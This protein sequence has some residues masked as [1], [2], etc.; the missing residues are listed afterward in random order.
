MYDRPTRLPILGLSQP[1]SDTYSD[2]QE[3]L[4]SHMNNYMKALSC[5]THQQPMNIH[6]DRLNSPYLP[7][8]ACIISTPQHQS[9]QV[10]GSYTQTGPSNN[11]IT[12]SNLSIVTS[13]GPNLQTPVHS[14]APVPPVPSNNN[15]TAQTAPATNNNMTAH[16][17]SA[18]NM[19]SHSIPMNSLGTH[20]ISTNALPAYT[21]S[22]NNVTNHNVSTSNQIITTQASSHVIAPQVSVAQSTAVQAQTH[23]TTQTTADSHSGHMVMI[24]T[25]GKTYADSFYVICPQ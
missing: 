17:I 20:T 10:L 3:A 12:N 25:D 4:L 7:P 9:S 22:A 6:N 14:N 16:T 2:E 11:Q 23:L 19:N 13:L 1:S 21:I 5:P 24:H 15:L 18:N 8:T